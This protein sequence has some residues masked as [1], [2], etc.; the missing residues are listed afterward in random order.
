MNSQ[1]ILHIL[2]YKTHRNVIEVSLI[3]IS[4]NTA[5][6]VTSLEMEEEVVQMLRC[7][8][9]G[10]AKYCQKNF[11]ILQRFLSSKSERGAFPTESTHQSG[12]PISTWIVNLKKRPVR[13]HYFSLAINFINSSTIGNLNFFFILLILCLFF[14]F[15]F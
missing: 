8:M 6:Y 5:C 7:V 9:I 2:I 14:W 1:F 15:W 4:K 3:W 11:V 12:L 10:Y 13:V